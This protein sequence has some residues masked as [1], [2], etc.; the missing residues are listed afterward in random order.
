MANE[1]SISYPG[2][3]ATLYVIIRKP[4]DGTVWNG[5]AFGSWSNG[6][7][8]SYDIALTNAL[9]DLYQADFP[10]GIDAGSY[11]ISYYRQDG[12]SPAITDL[13]LRTV[14]R[15]WNGASLAEDSSVSL[16][17]YALTNLTFV[18]RYMGISNT[19]NDT[20]L[21]ELINAISDRI[22][23]ACGR[24]FITRD[25]SEW[26]WSSGEAIV[27]NQFP[28]KYLTRVLGGARDAFSVV[29]SSGTATAATFGITPT[30]VRLLSV[31][32]TGAATTTTLALATYGSA[33]ALIDAINAI[34]GWSATLSLNCPSADL[35][36]QGSRNV[37]NV[38]V[39]ASYASD[40]VMN[41]CDYN[42]GH[43]YLSRYSPLSANCWG[44]GD[45]DCDYAR[46]RHGGRWVLV[47]YSA[48]YDSIA[49]LPA[50]I[51]MIARE[52]V[53]A[54]FDEADKDLNVQSETIDQYSY[55]LANSVEISDRQMSKLRPFAKVA[56]AGTFNQ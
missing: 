14:H 6:S 31:D 55:T 34:S 11:V 2:D 40:D 42:L 30:S 27:L 32:S 15:S 24:Q 5:S 9:G 46:K 26:Y 29:Y 8:G 53:K 18:K 4:S 22:E 21:T 16:S 44:P 49:A 45:F 43:L 23:R 25:Y 51:E 33:S 38:S 12:G 13:L 47:K 52:L 56:L 10:T 20:L 28:I 1:L 3:S 19:T 39:A 17:T 54:A 37:L 48:G 36:Q 7:I 41:D 35:H 50:D